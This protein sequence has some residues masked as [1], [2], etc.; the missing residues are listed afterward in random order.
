MKKKIKLSTGRV[1]L[2]EVDVPTFLLQRE[3]KFPCFYLSPNFEKI[4]PFPSKLAF[5]V[6]RSRPLPTEV[7]LVGHRVMEK[8]GTT[9]PHLGMW[10][11]HLKKRMLWLISFQFW[12]KYHF[13]PICHAHFWSVS[14]AGIVKYTVR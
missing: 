8:I 9:S 2:P 4:W 11:Y 12:S 5:S 6:L 3:T 14:D 1:R 13:F 7:G 10:F